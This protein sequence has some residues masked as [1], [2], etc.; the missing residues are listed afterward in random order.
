MQYFDWETLSAE[1]QAAVLARPVVVQQS[2]VQ[3][4]VA[5]ILEQVRRDGDEALRVLTA[6]WDGVTLQDFRVSEREFAEARAALSDSEYQALGMAYRNIHAFHTAQ[7]PEPLRV[8]TLPGLV[9]ER[10][11][12]P[13]ARVG[14]YVP[15]GSAPLPSTVLMLGVPSQLAANPERVLCTPPNAAGLVNP[16]ILAAA[17]LCGIRAVYKVGGAQ[18][19][20]A[21]AF[22]TKTLPAVDKIFGPGNAYV[23]AAKQQ[24]SQT[25]GGVAIDMPAGPSELLVIADDEADA[26]FVAADLLSQAEHGPDSQVLLLCFSEAF[27]RRV[28][29]TV[30]EQLANL[31]RAAIARQ[32]LAQSRFIRVSSPQSAL[33]IA[34][35][36][37]PEH[38]SLQ[39]REAQNCLAA[40]DTAGSVFIG[41]YTPESLGDYASGTNHVLPTYGHARAYSGLGVSDFQRSMSVQQASADALRAIG[42]VVE[43][44]ADAEQ[45]FGHKNAVSLRLAALRRSA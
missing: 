8:E 9:C 35:R 39:L 6:R 27:A 5:D 33:A 37:A 16:W 19:I 21:M 29:A 25:L 20:A 12:R 15:G 40:I 32:S 14:L 4:R 2:A 10:L 23:T 22:G 17:E 36:Y 26:E 38:L 41:A 42:P 44:L 1:A 7:R 31:P 45:L 28:Q 11:V 24:V 34:N 13:V 43:C 18:A 30:A 3:A